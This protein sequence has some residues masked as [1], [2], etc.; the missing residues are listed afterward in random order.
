[1]QYFLPEH[2]TWNGENDE[3]FF[4]RETSLYNVL[5]YYDEPRMKGRQAVVQ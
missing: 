3:V 4:R 5:T 1:M 2:G